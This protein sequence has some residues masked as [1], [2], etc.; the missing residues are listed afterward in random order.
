MNRVNL[1][2][3][4]LLSL[5]FYWWCQ[6][7]DEPPPPSEEFYE[8]PE[9]DETIQ[10]DP[11][12]KP[13]PVASET[14][15]DPVFIPKTE[16]VQPVKRRRKKRKK[17]GDLGPDFLPFDSEGRLIV[18]QV[19]I[20]GEHLTFHGDLLLGKASDLEKLKKR[21]PLKISKPRPW[22]SKEIP[23]VIEEGLANEIAV[24]EAV[25]TFNQ[26]T[27]IKF[28]PRDQQKNYIYFRKGSQNC[29]SYVGFQGGRQPISLSPG[30]QTPQICHEILHALAFF[31]EQNRGDRDDHVTVDWENIDPSHQINFKKIPLDF[32]HL[33]GETFTFDTIM[34]YHSSVFALDPE[35]PAMVTRSGESITPYPG[36]L[37]PTDIRRVNRLYP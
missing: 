37:S 28:I 32:M 21:G 20:D 5:F 10:E 35:L 18:T 9:E 33:S 29:Y 8:E 16:P 26:Y 14:S 30:C 4:G 11:A 2:L 7:N 17:Y 19:T 3:I 12:P 6:P 31:H 23:Y 13:P 1:T 15:T 22:P 25:A 27:N 24:E 36:I 34:I